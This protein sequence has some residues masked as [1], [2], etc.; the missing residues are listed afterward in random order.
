MFNLAPDRHT[1]T[2]EITGMS[3]QHCVGAVRD[4]L[5]GVQNAVVESVEIGSARVDAGPEATREILIEAVEA[6]GFDVVGGASAPA[7]R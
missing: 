4:A 3:C 1:E 6:A 2:L 7:P 5:A